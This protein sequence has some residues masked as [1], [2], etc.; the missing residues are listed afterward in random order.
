M[1]IVKE[2]K[3][4]P[5]QVICDE[6][7]CC[8]ADADEH[9]QD[10][11]CETCDMYL[12][13]LNYEKTLAVMR[14]Y[15]NIGLYRGKCKNKNMWTEGFLYWVYCDGVPTPY[16]SNRALCCSDSFD[17]DDVVLPETITQYT[18]HEVDGYLI[19]VGDIVETV[20]MTNYNGLIKKQTIRAVVT[21]DAESSQFV[22]D[23]DDSTYSFSTWDWENS[24]IV[25]NIW[26]DPDMKV[27][28]RV[29]YI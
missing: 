22:F 6:W 16:I 3:N 11:H 15:G 5:P 29:E 12:D 1:D 27:G 17:A 2:L 20:V 14:K 7:R 26:N 9:A 19:F 25:G 8:A 13:L 18:G 21:W 24:N 28:V 10:L 4:Y 23:A